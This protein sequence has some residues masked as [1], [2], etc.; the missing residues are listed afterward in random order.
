[1]LARIISLADS[2]DA[3]TADRPYRQSLST[4]KVQEELQRNAGVQFDPQMVSLFLKR[5]NSNGFTLPTYLSSSL[6]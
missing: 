3:M 1:L 6:H 4:K 5:F 2:Y